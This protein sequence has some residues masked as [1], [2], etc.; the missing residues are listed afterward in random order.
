MLFRAVLRGEAETSKSRGFPA[1][2]SLCRGADWEVDTVRKSAL[3]VHAR[4]SPQHLHI[5]DQRL[6]STLVTTHEG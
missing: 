5:H 1:S 4:R 3:P 2:E 6:E